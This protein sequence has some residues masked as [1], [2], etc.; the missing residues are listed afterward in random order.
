[1]PICQ[2]YFIDYK[3]FENILYDTILSSVRNLLNNEQQGFRP[4]NPVYRIFSQY[5]CELLDEQSQV[6][7]VYLDFQKAIDQ[8]NH[9]LLLPKLN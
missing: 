4:K 1:M 2:S 9:Y 7:V 6:S 8:I 3:N 5:L